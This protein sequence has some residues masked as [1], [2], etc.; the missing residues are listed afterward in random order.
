MH[1][2]AY[3]PYLKVAFLYLL[4]FIL[5]P[6][7]SGCSNDAEANEERTVKNISNL[8]KVPPTRQSEDYTCGIT[9]VQSLI[10]Y[11]GI[12]ERQNKLIEAMRPDPEMG[13]NYKN[14]ITYLESLGLE[15]TAL[16]NMSLEQLKNHIDARQPVLLAIQAWMSPPIDWSTYDE[17]HYV[18]AIGYDTENFYFMDPSTLGNYTYIPTDEFLMRWHDHDSYSDTDLK[19]FGI[20]VNNP[21]QGS[22]NPD[23]IVRLR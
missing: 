23:S 3:K 4:L 13:T 2:P 7:F 15:A 5:L 17:G 6:S 22:Y 16:T 14:I 20:V 19:Q 9:A 1:T 11:Y 10:G 8:I 21:A 12:D 18:V